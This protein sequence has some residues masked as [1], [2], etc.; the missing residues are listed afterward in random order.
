MYTDPDGFYSKLTQCNKNNY[1]MIKPVIRILKHWNIQKN[2]RDLPSYV[3]EKQI[4]E[5]LMNVNWFCHSYTDYL[6]SALEHLTYHTDEY[7]VNLAIVC[8][9]EALRLEKN[10][11]YVPASIMIKMAFPDV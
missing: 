3:L 9:N 1:F 7:T 4:A 10:Q 11:H 5:D 2:K 6:K 8:I